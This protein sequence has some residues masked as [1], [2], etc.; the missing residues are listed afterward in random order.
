M[1]KENVEAVQRAYEAFLRG[2]VDEAFASLDPDIVFKPTHEVP[3]QGREGVRAS[4]ERW[5]APFEG[6]EMILEEPIDAGD[7]VIQPI[8]FRG[9]GRGS[10]IEVESRFFQVFTIQDGRAVL[11]EEFTNRS[12]AFEAAGLSKQDAHAES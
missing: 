1:S 10:G 9:R 2:D 12:E 11:W 6:Q 4:L 3:V 5:Q 8:L 7:R